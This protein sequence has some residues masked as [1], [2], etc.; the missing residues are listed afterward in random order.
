MSDAT[1]R[2]VD[3]LRRNIATF[4]LLFSVQKYVVE[5]AI[6]KM[7][8]ADLHR[9]NVEKDIIIPFDDSEALV[10]LKVIDECVGSFI[11]VEMSLDQ[12]GEELDLSFEII[13]N[14][15][16]YDSDEHDPDLYPYLLS[17]SAYPETHMKKELEYLATEYLYFKIPIK[18]KEIPSDDN[19]GII[20]QSEW[21]TEHS[22][23]N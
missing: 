3:D 12:L 15:A 19:E 23:W 13:R 14:D 7:N 9:L 8:E 11:D 16:E 2:T 5:E 10:S 20:K 4:R 17:I 18:F 21:Q 1:I 6:S 22:T